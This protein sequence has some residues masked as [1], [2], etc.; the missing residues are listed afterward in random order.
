MPLCFEL[1]LPQKKNMAIA[2]FASTLK[3]HFFATWCGLFYSL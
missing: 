2:Y 1:I 3:I